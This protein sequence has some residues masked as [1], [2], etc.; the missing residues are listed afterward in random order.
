MADQ[1]YDV[2]VIGAG[3][4]GLVCAAYLARSGLKV[5]VLERSDRI[6]GACVTEELFPGFR[7]ST[8]SYSL[9]LL[10]PDVVE[11]LGLKLDIRPKD[12]QLFAPFPDGGGLVLW[13]DPQRRHDAIA[14]ISKPDADALPVFEELFE[15]ASRRLRPLLSFAATRK[16][17]RRAFRF[18]EVEGLFAKTVDSSIAELCEEHFE[19][20][21]MRGLTAS[22]GI[23]GSAAGPRTPGTAYVY[24]HHAFGLAAGQPGVWGFVRGGMGAITAALAD[25]VRAAGGE[26]RLE[27]EVASVKLDGARR[28]SGVVLADG[29]E[30]E[31]AVVCSNADPK[32]TAAFVPVDA[33]APEYAQDV[34][35]L[36]TDGTVVKV[37]CALS[38]LPRFTGMEP[39]DG[40][41]PE[42][43]GT[44]TIAPSI[45]YLE[46][47][48]T[49][50][51]E[52]RPA[53][54][55]FC[56]AWIQSASEPELAP[57]GKHTLSV[58]AQ[59]APYE[60]AEGSWDER[61][62]EIGDLVLA[63]L[64]E[65]APGL[66]SLV[67]DRLVLGP[68]DLE[69]RFGLTGGNIFHGEILPD[70]LFDKRPAATWHRYRLPIAGLYLCGSGAHPGGGVCGAPGRNAARA[71]MEDKVAAGTARP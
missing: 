35:L 44:I 49:A 5:V 54:K 25:V 10:E 24:L 8:A 51:G 31:A 33:L 14:E 62:D 37:N 2:V 52:G 66:T 41:G 58:F 7:I 16:Q 56:E 18:S 61:R 40:P 46:D 15:E 29:E 4:N 26:I 50:A 36:P 65:Y 69:A 48:A 6:G 63:T 12:P 20:D 70:W 55:M 19:S 30:I 17:A 67:E 60:L 28:A 3:H 13:H 11:D 68:P 43:L 64:E 21:L 57:E 42:H 39:H 32:R 1:G 38:G 27:A 34:E 23:I 59:Y 9:S 47:A 45:D 22:Q 53:P 71:V